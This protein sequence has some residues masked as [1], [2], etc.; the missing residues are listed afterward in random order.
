MEAGDRRTDHTKRD[1]IDEIESAVERH[2]KETK[3]AIEQITAAYRRFARVTTTILAVLC[4]ATL[5]AAILSIYLLGQNGQRADEI[6]QERANSVR[7]SCLE[8]NARHDKT[9]AKLDKLVADIKDPAEKARAQ[10]NIG[11]TVALIEALAPKQD[12][13]ALVRKAVSDERKGGAGD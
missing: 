7:S 2:S 6:Q 5:G 9:L 4:V 12:C 11:G 13:T 3:E 8:Q 10:A 1:R